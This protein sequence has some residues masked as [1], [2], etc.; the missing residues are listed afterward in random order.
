MIVIAI[1]NQTGGVGKTTTAI[2]LAAEG[3]V[4]SPE[5]VEF[6]HMNKTAVLIRSA[7][8]MGA[9]IGGAD[10][11]EMECLSLYAE[12]IGMAFQIADDILDETST[13]I[14]L[15]KPA[16]SDV[17]QNKLTYPAVHGLD[18]ARD[19]VQQL[20]GDAITL[21]A[22]LRR[23]TEPLSEMATFLMNRRY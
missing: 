19:K 16:G 7:V 11:A 10:E 6:I 20:T 15:G 17:K 5:L 9:V 1:A 13:D 22:P 21:L 8:R 2:N 3:Q 23:N 4:P 12:K 14:I 18:A